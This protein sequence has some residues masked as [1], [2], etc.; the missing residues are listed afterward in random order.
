[1]GEIMDEWAS[2][3]DRK[4]EKQT[5]LVQNDAPVEVK[6]IGVKRFPA[7]DDRLCLLLSR[8]IIF[9]VSEIKKKTL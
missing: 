2:K 8:L 1:M 5:S 3:R 7:F 6:H 4:E 9:Q